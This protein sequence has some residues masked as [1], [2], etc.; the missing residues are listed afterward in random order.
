[1][2]DRILEVLTRLEVELHQAE[3]RCDRERLQELLHPTFFEFGRSGQRYDRATV[4]SEFSDVDE[5]E[6][7]RSRNFEITALADDAVLLTYLSAHVAADGCE[8]RH[9]LRSSIWIH[10]NSGWQMLFHQGTPSDRGMEEG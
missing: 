1:M 8:Y 3:T 7:V 5:L 2:T 6:P 4:L 10:G 9:T